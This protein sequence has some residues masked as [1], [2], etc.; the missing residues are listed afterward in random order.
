MKKSI[1]LLFISF[2][3]INCQGQAKK[4]IQTLSVKNY[5]EKLDA[6]KNPQLIDVRTPNEYTSG[7]IME[8]KNINW[9]GT[10]FI[11]EVEKLDKTKPVFVYCKVGGRSAQAASK[12]AELG[13]KE[14]Y[15][16]EGGIDAWKAVEN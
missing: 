2:L 13:F 4:E 14:I 9:N 16:L 10:N 1:L 5:T 6:T 8:A 3:F 7:K 11:S 12:L 15:N